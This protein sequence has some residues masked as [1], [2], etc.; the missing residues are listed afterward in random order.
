MFK[1]FFPYFG[2][3]KKYAILTPILVIIEVFMNI[4]IPYLMSLLIDRGILGYSKDQILKIGII[5]IIATLISLFSGITSGITATRA[6][7]GLAKNLRFNMFK[8]ICN[9][10]FRNLDEFKKGSIVTRM[11]TDVQYVQ[12]AMQM[13]TR[14]AVRA[15]LTLLFAFIMSFRLQSHL[16]IYFVLIIP[17]IS[18]GMAYITR[19]AYPI[20]QRVFKITDD[21]NTMVSENLLGIRV[22]KSYVREDKERENFN[23]ISQKMFRNYRL[24]SRLIALSGPLMQFSTYLMSLII[25]WLGSHFI[26]RGTMSTGA[27]TSMITYSIQIQISLL[28]LSMVIVQLTIAKNA[29]QRIMEVINTSSDILNPIEPIK[30]VVDGS[31]EFKNVNFSYNDDPNKLVLKDINLKISSGDYVGIIGPTGSS[32]ST[33]V[34][35]I[36]RLYDVYSGSVL[37]GGID[38]KDYDLKSLRDEVSFVLQHNVLFSGTLRENLKWADENL[39]DEKMLKALKVSNALDFINA[40]DG[41]DTIVERGGTNFSGG[42]KQRLCI[43]RA[44]LKN[45]KVLIM[46]DCTSAL[47]NSTE[48]SIINSINTLNPH[49]TKILISQRVNSLKNCDYIIV[50][51]EGKIE[52][53]GSHENLIKSSEIYRE[54]YESQQK[55]GD[56]D[57]KE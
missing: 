12:M 27:L 33:L 49:L 15:P 19:R 29:S 40:K 23:H 24:V 43:A 21:L 44:I 53:I 9:F 35:L 50:L 45:P 28:I 7:A 25:A 48:S 10:S 54:I 5:L 42:Q 6:S 57:V 46:D 16:A 1:T 20:F 22:V 34:Q 13:S 38:V 56:F 26:V 31:V 11:S 3:Y 32:K 17:I 47:D 37:V 51:N 39:N 2:Q 14:I 18:L 52:N 30:E 41:L 8:N 36:P 55:G 4:A